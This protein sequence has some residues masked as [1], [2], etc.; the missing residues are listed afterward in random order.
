MV[1]L[2]RSLFF[3]FFMLCFSLFSISM[4][5]VIKMLV[6][7]SLRGRLNLPKKYS[8][9]SLFTVA[10]ITHFSKSYFFFFTF[11]L[12]QSIQGLLCSKG[13]IKTLHDY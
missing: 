3:F 4:Q 2:E 7:D 5:S 11:S 6:L 9:S 12:F 10:D 8:C 13:L 1:A